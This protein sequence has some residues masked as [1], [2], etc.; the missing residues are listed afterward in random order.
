MKW[1][2]ILTG[3]AGDGTVEDPYRPQL[4]DDYAL[5]EWRDATGQEA[6]TLPG[7]PNLFNVIVLVEESVLDSIE[8]DPTYNVLWSDDA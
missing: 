2:E 1:A 5:V 3:W 6:G 7:D 8:A 4:A